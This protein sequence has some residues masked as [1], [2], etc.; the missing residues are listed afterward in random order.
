MI[1]KTRVSFLIDTGSNISILNKNIADSWSKKSDLV[2]EPVY[3][4]LVTVTGE[5]APLHGKA[6]FLISLDSQNLAH[7][8]YLADINNDGILGIDFLQRFC[9]NVLLNERC[10]ESGGERISCYSLKNDGNTA[11]CQVTVK[12]NVV[13]P[14]ESEI[15]LP[16]K[17]IGP[18]SHTVGIIEPLQKFVLKSGLL[19]AKSI[20]DIKNG[21][22]QIR[23]VNLGY[24]PFTVYKGTVAAIYESIT[25]P[26]IKSLDKISVNN[27]SL[28]ESLPVH[29]MPVFDKTD[30]SLSEEQKLT[31]QQLL[32][33][34]QNLFSKDADDIGR[35]HLVEHTI[36]M[37]NAKPVKLPPYRIP[38][39][40]RE[41]AEREIK[42][43]E[44]S[45]IIEP[46]CSPWSSPVVM[47]AKPDGSVRFCCD[48]RKLNE[49]TIKDSQPLP[50]IDDTLDALSGS[51]WFSTIDLKSGFWQIAMS[52]KDKPKTSFSIQGSGLWQFRAMPYGLCCAPATFERLMERILSGL[53]WQICLVYLDDIV[54]YSK[55]FTEHIENLETAFA[56]LWKPI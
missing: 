52:E 16:G 19:I 2:I 34:H 35:T 11:C 21:S 53:T 25:E 31:V 26:S 20:V 29:L 6:N 15:I 23:V 43:M 56:R 5:T 9:C 33:K 49:L 17:L 46:S 36:D 37:G 48:F 30:I 32:V 39:A 51:V 50:R 22:I 14:P 27:T 8:L 13:I 28:Q 38:L 24:E 10:I 44:E 7:N 12:E 42:K 4:S 41:V 1:N 18:N 55:T 47:V 54:V 3:Q 40:K 45:G